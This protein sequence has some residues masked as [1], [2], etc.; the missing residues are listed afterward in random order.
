MFDDPAERAVTEA[1]RLDSKRDAIAPRQG[2][3]A[4][5]PW[6]SHLCRQ[7][8][9]QNAETSPTGIQSGRIFLMTAAV[10]GQAD[11]NSIDC[12]TSLGTSSRVMGSNPNL[13]KNF[14][15]VVVN[16]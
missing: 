9:S 7:L 10:D 1:V 15:A 16:R 5:E 2:A 4:T 8:E 6:R 13:G 3:P 12:R 11:V 14:S